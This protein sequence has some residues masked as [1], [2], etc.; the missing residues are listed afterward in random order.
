MYLLHV[1]GMYMGMCVCVG[2]S[3]VEIGVEAFLGY[4]TLCTETQSLPDD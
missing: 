2:T 1:C 4:S 3:D